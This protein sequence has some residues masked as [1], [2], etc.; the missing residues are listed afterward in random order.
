MGVGELI[1]YGGD[2]EKS[3]TTRNLE[4]PTVTD[5]LKMKKAKLEKQLADV[6]AAIDALESNPGVEKVLN[7]ISKT[8]RY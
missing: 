8:G 3:P 5:N 7:L 1:N 2:C 6:N 4:E